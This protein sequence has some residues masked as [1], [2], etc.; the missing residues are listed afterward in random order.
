MMIILLI[1]LLVSCSTL[2][3]GRDGVDLSV[4]TSLETWKC[5]QQDH[6]I[7]Y[8]KIRV[9]RNVGQV[10]SNATMSIK[11]ATHVLGHNVDAYIFPC[12]STSAYAIS[13]NVTCPSAEEQ[14][15]ELLNYLT[16]HDISFAVNGVHRQQYSLGRLWLDIED[17]VPAKYFD[18]NITVNTNFLTDIVSAMNMKNI[19]IGIYTTK[20]YW[21]NI[22]G[23]I[24]GYDIYPLWYPRYDGLNDMSFFAPFAGWDSVDIKQTNGNV[25]YCDLSQVDSDYMLD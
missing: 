4:E 15:D 1:V 6:N 14:I 22:M 19:P 2:C 21:T 23:G 24:M 11:L 7:S 3:L 25:G 9:Y 5:L 10:D 20:T 18:S 17:E 8:A 12:I 16:D 13:K